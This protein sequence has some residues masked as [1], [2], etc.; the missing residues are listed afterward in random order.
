MKK[1]ILASILTLSFS[2]FAQ[3]G[4]PEPVSTPPMPIEGEGTIQKTDQKIE[5]Q[6]DKLKKKKSHTKKNKHKK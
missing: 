3:T 1:I 4:H 2:V 5:L 6:T